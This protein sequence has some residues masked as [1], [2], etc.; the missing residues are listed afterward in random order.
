MS[1]IRSIFL[2]RPAPA[3]APP[4]TITITFTIKQIEALKSLLTEADHAERQYV[5]EN[6]DEYDYN[7]EDQLT[8][9]NEIGAGKTAF[10]NIQRVWNAI[11]KKDEADEDKEESDEEMK[12]RGAMDG[13]GFV[14]CGHCGKG[15]G[16]H[17]T[18]DCPDHE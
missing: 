7:A 11:N 12:A 15:G 16:S 4:A 6:Y 14:V 5:S 8:H 2:S 3:A 13:D 17:A 1:T 10:A 18:E 9:L